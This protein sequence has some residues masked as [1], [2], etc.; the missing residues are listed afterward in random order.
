MG[1]HSKTIMQQIQCG[2]DMISSV[3]HNS[4]GASVLEKTGGEIA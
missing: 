3:Y 2:Y 4:N 1:V